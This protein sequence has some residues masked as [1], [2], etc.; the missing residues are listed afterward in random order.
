[1]RILLVDGNLSGAHKY[2]D[3][4]TI[5]IVGVL[6]AIEPTVNHV[7]NGNHFKIRG[8]AAPPAPLVPA[9]M[10]KYCK[11]LNAEKHYKYSNITEEGLPGSEAQAERCGIPQGKVVVWYSACEM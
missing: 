1:M 5:R 2:R 11:G 7:Y 3:A 10:H 6:R 4:G 8:V 9:P